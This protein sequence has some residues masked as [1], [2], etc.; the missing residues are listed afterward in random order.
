[1]KTCQVP[2]AWTVAIVAILLLPGCGDSGPPKYRLSGKVTY[3][4]KP[5]SYGDIRFEPKSGLNNVQTMAFARFRDGQYETEVVGGPH[6]VY[7]RD[8]TGDVDM[9]D[10]ANPAGK[11]M[12]QMEYRG[13][14]DLPPH[15]QVPAGSFEKDIDV[16]TTH[17]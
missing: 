17:Q 10:S 9:G 2:L 11:A 12:F 7:V 14:T 5:I 13:E 4:G 16:P 6:W 8:L 3:G 15:D 1:M